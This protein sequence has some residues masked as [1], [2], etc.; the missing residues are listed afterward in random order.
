MK[1]TK[2][3]KT[4]TRPD[5][6]PMTEQEYRQAPGI[7][8]SSLKVMERSPA[9]YRAALDEPNES[10]AAQVFGTVLHAVVLEPT[11]ECYVIRPEGMKFTTSEGKAWRDSQTLPIL[12]VDD[13][14]RIK[15][16]LVRLHEHPIVS[17]LLKSAQTE[18]ACFGTHANG[19]QIKGRIDILAK[20]KK[21]VVIA[22][23]KTTDD[24]SPMAFDRSVRKYRYDRQAAFYLDL[25]GSDRFLFVAVEKEAPFAVAVYELSQ[26]MIERARRDNDLDLRTLKKCMETDVWPA[27]GEQVHELN[28]F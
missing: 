21:K 4:D 3:Q 2:K 10:T 17:S 25:T 7:N 23:I 24:A 6:R 20:Y 26:Q 5:I 12:D 9:H 18:V 19:L 22:D 1:R 28:G 13:D 15:S 16:M 8:I 14:C 11:R 27:Y